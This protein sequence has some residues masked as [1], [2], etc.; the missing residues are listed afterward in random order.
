LKPIDDAFSYHFL[1]EDSEI[2]RVDKPDWCYTY[3]YE[4]LEGNI[5]ALS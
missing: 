3:L 1:R 5:N 4:F 2:S